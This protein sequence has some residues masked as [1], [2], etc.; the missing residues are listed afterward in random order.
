MFHELSEDKLK[1]KP[2]K[3][4]LSE[5]QISEIIEMALSD[6][7]SF[8]NIQFQHGIDANQVK[9]IM[10]KNL[11]PGSYRAWRERVKAFSSR[12]KFYK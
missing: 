7:V 9:I 3:Q 8:E 2:N 6:H 1:A 10:K 4:A 5:A 12:R 11:K